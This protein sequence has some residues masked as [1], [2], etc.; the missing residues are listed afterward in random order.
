M[1]ENKPKSG[2][3]RTSMEEASTRREYPICYNTRCPENC[4][5]H[6]KVSDCP[7]H[8]GEMEAGLAF[9]E[10]RKVRWKRRFEK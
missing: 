10:R 9:E 3:L 8:R 1:T 6:H 7:F 5:Y 2:A 4:I